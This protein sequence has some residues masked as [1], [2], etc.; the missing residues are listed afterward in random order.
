[1]IASDSFSVLTTL[2]GICLSVISKVLER[3]VANKLTKHLEGNNI[4][5]IAQ[6]GFR[7]SHSCLSNLLLTLDDWT[8]AIDNGNPIHACYL[9]MSKAFDHLSEETMEDRLLHLQATGIDL[10]PGERLTDHNADDKL[11]LFDNLQC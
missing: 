1:M 9:D 5:S 8:L 10:P 2:H 7:K 4:L 3:L 11:L 6:H